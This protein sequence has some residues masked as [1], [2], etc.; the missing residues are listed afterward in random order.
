MTAVPT[1]PPVLDEPELSAPDLD[2]P[3]EDE[4]PAALIDDEIFEVPEPTAEEPAD[5]EGG[6]GVVTRI[7]LPKDL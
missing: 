2:L 5:G 7:P 4:A 6:G 3:L 1:Q